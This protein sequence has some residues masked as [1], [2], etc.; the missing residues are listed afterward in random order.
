MKIKTSRGNIC[1]LQVRIRF[2]KVLFLW[3]GETISIRGDPGVLCIGDFPN[4]INHLASGSTASIS[5][6]AT[7]GF[8]SDHVIVVTSQW[9]RWRFKSLASLLFTQLFVQKHIKENIKAPRHW[10]LT[11]KMSPFDDVIMLC[12]LDQGPCVLCDICPKRIL[13]WNLVKNCL[14]ITYLA[15]AQSF[16]NLAQITAV[17]LCT[18][19]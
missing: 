10:P 16:W 11:R 15:V 5:T 3:N 1:T 18:I 7:N 14:L 19:F 6:C 8:K 13:N 4:R 9:A 12:Y 17:I 2:A